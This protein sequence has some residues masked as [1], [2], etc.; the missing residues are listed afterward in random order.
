M[1]ILDKWLGYSMDNPIRQLRDAVRE[2]ARVH[3][4]Y[5]NVF[6]TPDG[7]RVLRHLMK[8]GGITKPSYV[9]GDPY[10]TAFNEGR[11]HLVLSILKFI[12]KSHDELLKA[13]EEGTENEIT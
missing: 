9:A 13:I 8:V 4:S 5:Q 3:E 2:R 6:N 10:T 1:W 11:R 12:H 7:E